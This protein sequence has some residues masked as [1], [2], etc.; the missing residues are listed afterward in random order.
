MVKIKSSEI[1]PEHVYLNRRQLIVGMGALAAASVLAA[2]AGEPEGAAPA[3]SPT[4]APA[5]GVPLDPT[6]KA[7]QLETML[8]P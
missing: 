3:A 4:A 7:E 5:T 1:T 8:T 2:C 6:A